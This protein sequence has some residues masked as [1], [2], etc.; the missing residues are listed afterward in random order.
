MGS[1]LSITNDTQDTYYCKIGP[2]NEAIRWSTYIVDNLLDALEFPGSDYVKFAFGLITESIVNLQ[3]LTPMSV[4]KIFDWMQNSGSN[5]GTVLTNF[6]V[7]SEAD[8]LTNTNGYTKLPPGKKMF[9]A[10]KTLSL[11]LAANCKRV[12]T[13]IDYTSKRMYVLHD[14]VNMDPIATGA[15]DN[16]VLDHRIQWWLDKN[17]RGEQVKVEIL[18]P[19]G[20]GSWEDLSYNKESFL[21]KFKE[22][23]TY[24]V[25]CYTKSTIGGYPTVPCLIR[26]QMACSPDYEQ[27]QNVCSC[28]NML[29][30]SRNV[31]N[32]NW[33]NWINSC[34]SDVDGGMFPS[35]KCDAA[36]KTMLDKEFYLNTKKDSKGSISFYK[37]RVSIESI[38]SWNEILWSKPQ[39]TSNYM[40]KKDGVTGRPMEEC[41]IGLQ[42][43]CA[44]YNG[45][46]PNMGF[47]ACECKYAVLAARDQLNN[48]WKDWITQCI[49][50][51]GQKPFD[52]GKHC[53]TAYNVMVKKNE[54]FY[55]NAVNV[56]GNNNICTTVTNMT[57]VPFE[58]FAG[59]A[60][61]LWS[62]AKECKM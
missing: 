19:D 30:Q 35:D 50:Q 60:L 39:C 7:Q 51:Y 3:G 32:D 61:K 56:I 17:G 10:R 25:E 46:D 8:S 34:S 47:T 57:S 27:F 18:P 1:N 41:L 36:I 9:S 13:K 23:P 58:N 24:P 54:V 21:Q 44:R 29:L 5:L 52:D 20:W 37:E 59:G 2:S 40:C 15:T 28:T 48:N 45:P 6:I 11:L 42:D 22:R 31:M 43:K 26:L 4:S 33:K 55:R 62:R 38:K 49:W 53:E 12:T 14:A 16:S